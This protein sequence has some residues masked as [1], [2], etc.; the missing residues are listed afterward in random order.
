MKIIFFDPK[1]FKIQ[2]NLFKT[3]SMYS[4]GMD[5]RNILEIEVNVLLFMDIL[6][7]V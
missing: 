4:T 2:N 6:F 3:F 5:R 7:A 1:V